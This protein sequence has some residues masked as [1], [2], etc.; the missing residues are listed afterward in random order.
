[1]A[2]AVANF[3]GM[4]LLCLQFCIDI[5][6]RLNIAAGGVLYLT[7]ASGKIRTE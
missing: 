2:T 7:V 5:F 1:M 3:L 6:V 4:T